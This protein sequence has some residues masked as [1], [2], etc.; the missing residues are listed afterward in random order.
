MSAQQEG[1]QRGRT[2]DDDRD[3][4]CGAGAS[5]CLSRS[6]HA[7]CRSLAGRHREKACARFAA[8]N[9]TSLGGRRLADL[10]IDFEL[11]VNT[12]ASYSLNRVDADYFEAGG[13]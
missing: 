7:R 10:M 1:R 3:A 5:S 6:L 4:K 8:G 12:V 13:V 11:G 2:H 9:K